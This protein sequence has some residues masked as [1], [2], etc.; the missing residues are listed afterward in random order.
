MKPFWTWTFWPTMGQMMKVTPPCH[1]VSYFDIIIDKFFLVQSL[2]NIV[3][4]K[5]CLV[6]DK[7]LL[8]VGPASTPTSSTSSPPQGVEEPPSPHGAW[9]GMFSGS[10]GSFFGGS[11]GAFGRLAYSARR[12]PG[13]P[14]KEGIKSTREGKVVR[15][16]VQFKYLL[17]AIPIN[18][19][20]YDLHMRKFCFIWQLKI[21]SCS[22]VLLTVWLFSN[23]T[24]RRLFISFFL[25]LLI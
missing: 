6:G 18:V 24:V 15:K 17:N 14:R 22:K 4:L 16:Q 5:F 21:E 25:F 3:Y 13:R 9:A 8:F 12:G 7:Y 20:T 10:V 1:P 2:V 23:L 11:G 19:M